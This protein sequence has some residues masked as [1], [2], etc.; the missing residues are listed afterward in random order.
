KLFG[1]SDSEMGMVLGK[2]VRTSGSG[3]EMGI[4]GGGIGVALET[5][6]FEI[7]GFE[8]LE[9]DYFELKDLDFHE[10]YFPD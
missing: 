4:T 3:T 2:V 8:N 5:V 7:L 6:G 10:N 9:H 1:I